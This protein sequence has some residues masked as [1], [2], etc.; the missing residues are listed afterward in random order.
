[1]VAYESAEE[2]T[3]IRSAGVT[4]NTY[5]NSYCQGGGN[6]SAYVDGTDNVENAV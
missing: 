4:K 6:T 2:G 3:D 5:F 1:M